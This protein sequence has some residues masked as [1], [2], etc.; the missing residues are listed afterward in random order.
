MAKEKMNRVQPT[1]KPTNF[2][3]F[4]NR[5]NFKQAVLNIQIWVGVLLPLARKFNRLPE[6]YTLSAN[7]ILVSICRLIDITLHGKKY[8]CHIKSCT[9][10]RTDK[11]FSGEHS[12][13]KLIHWRSAGKPELSTG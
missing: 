5:E 11:V 3:H 9:F 12:N 13:A 7:F 8:N 4:F 2:H 6:R 10:Y 1:E